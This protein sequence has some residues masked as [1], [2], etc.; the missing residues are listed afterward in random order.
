MLW[1]CN[2]EQLLWCWMLPEDLVL[3][4]EWRDQGHGQ[5][6]EKVLRTGCHPAFP[7]PLR[8]ALQR[9][10]GALGVQTNLSHAVF[11]E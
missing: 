6:Q 2:E 1:C 4:F 8:G 7:P 11:Q 10:G 5:S 3:Q 9:G